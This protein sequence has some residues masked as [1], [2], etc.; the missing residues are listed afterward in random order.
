VGSTFNPKGSVRWNPTDWLVLR[1]SASTTFKAPLAT[2]VSNNFVTALA[3]IA[4]A[5][6]VDARRH[7]VPLPLQPDQIGRV[8]GEILTRKS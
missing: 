1:G 4:A 3:G 6:K 5:A 8:L 7:V 2:Q